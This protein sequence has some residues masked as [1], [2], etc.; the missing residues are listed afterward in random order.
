MIGKT[1]SHYKILEKLGEGGMGVIY[2][3]EDTILK[4]TVAIKFLKQEELGSDEDKERFLRE[5]QVAASL[6]YPNI[7]SVYEIN[8]H[9]GQY[10]IVM[11]FIEGQSLE[12]KIKSLKKED[13]SLVQIDEFIKI[14]KQIANGLQEAHEHD[15]IHR[16]IKS[17]N[18]MITP[19]GQIKIMDFGLA[20][21]AKKESHQKKMGETPGTIVYMSP[22]Q[23]RGEDVDKRSDIWSLGVV[24][25]ELIS[26]Y[27]PFPGDSISSVRKNILY[28]KPVPIEKYR[29]D[30]PAKLKE[31]FAIFFKK[32][33]HSRYSSCKDILS[34]LEKLEQIDTL[35]T[36]K[37]EKTSQSKKRI[38]IPFLIFF[39]L[40]FSLVSFYLFKLN[41]NYQS[42]DS[43]LVKMAVLD[44]QY[45]G[46]VP[47]N[48]Y[49]SLGI[50]EDI[51]LRL[52]AIDRL[53]V[54][55]KG[56]ISRL[57]KISTN[58]YELGERLRVDYILSGSINRTNDNLTI[59][60]EIIDISK[61]QQIWTNTLQGTLNDIFL[62]RENLL[63]E[64]I[65]A[66]NISISSNHESQVFKKPALNIKAYDYYLR[67]QDYFQRHFRTN[68]E[69]A[70]KMFK[71]A[72]E[73]DP[74]YSL[75]YIGLGRTYLRKYLWYLQRDRALVDSAQYFIETAEKIDPISGE[76]HIAIGDLY[77]QKGPE[78]LDKAIQEYKKA[79]QLNPTNLDALRSLSRILWLTKQY[80]E[81]KRWSEQILKIHPVDPDAYIEIGFA[82]WLQGFSQHASECFDTA[83]ELQPDLP[84][85][86]G[87]KAYFCFL[88][89]M[90]EDAKILYEKTLELD[91]A[92]TQ[93][94]AVLAQIFF[95]N[96]DTRKAIDYYKKTVE[97]GGDGI[98][99][100][101][102]GLIYN[103]TN[104]K[105]QANV[106]FDSSKA[107]SLRF[108]ERNPD[109]HRWLT[110]LAIIH[111]VR[112][113][114]QEAVKLI[115]QAK[116]TNDFKTNI[117]RR[118]RVLMREA[119]VYS[120]L[121][122]I[123]KCI[124]TLQIILKDRVYSLQ[125][126]RHILGL[127]N[128]RSDPKFEKIIL[129]L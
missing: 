61:G 20:K 83:I 84:Y 105:D 22:E 44:F 74:N 100:F 11:S 104:N 64:V 31:M 87:Q 10:Y 95:I 33:I 80:D 24:L 101:R 25:Y 81:S 125:T 12:E 122:N 106:C 6:D 111:A 115:K 120:Q 38:V 117:L 110:D 79:I 121:K 88:N 17:A 23:T 82:N 94:L 30:V 91:P 7:C 71:K 65:H 59:L 99:Y 36:E 32:E 102:F 63:K 51:T 26:G 40:V 109:D 72:L 114:E 75:A 37:V 124:E 55:P 18:I 119:I 21:L 108:L 3:A 41:N 93:A 16:D 14:G 4:R 68:Y 127:E 86:Y 90:F 49:L 123:D 103:F 39:V 35:K 96:Q 27:L 29:N 50:T 5:A 43:S 28:K 9:A 73:I 112:G 116:N 42:F 92:S 70:I 53:L 34:D 58:I 128:L 97:K 45:L 46:D 126:V 69:I 15:I 76:V 129:N 48:S 62:L 54:L 66:L 60:G 56:D 8:Q 113:S 47:E 77:R 57:K 1:I 89:G 107:I 13:S 78:M 2:K 19:K 118:N 98:D 85:V 52:S 67:G